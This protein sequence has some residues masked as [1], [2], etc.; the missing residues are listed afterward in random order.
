S[1]WEL[2]HR[3]TRRPFRPQENT[4][5][6]SCRLDRAARSN[7]RCA[8]EKCFLDSGGADRSHLWRCLDRRAPAAFELGSRRRGRSILQPHGFVLPSRGRRWPI[9]LGACGGWAFSVKRSWLRLSRRSSHSCDRY[10]A[11][12]VDVARRSRQLLQSSPTEMIYR[13]LHWIAGIALYWFYREI[14]VVGDE[15][16]PARGPLLIAVNHQNALVDSL[17]AG[18]VIP[19][20][21]TMTAK[22]T[23]TVNPFIAA[24]FRTLGVVPLRRASDEP[25]K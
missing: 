21:I 20:R 23:L 16:I 3:T 14:R 15:K 5:V 11:R 13:F 1:Y 12:A 2:R 7:D 4:V 19:R 24:L 6:G 8:I 9:H 10:G 18:W 17:I 22:A 25:R